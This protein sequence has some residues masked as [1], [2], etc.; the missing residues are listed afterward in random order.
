M[1][2]RGLRKFDVQAVK[3]TAWAALRRR[4]LAEEPHCRICGAE[5]SDVDHIR[6]RREGGTDDR[7][8]LQA[9][10]RFCHSSKTTKARWK[11]KNGKVSRSSR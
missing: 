5:A 7:A 8:N 11:L 10:C 4:V 6:D 2:V 3:T 1:K 9:L